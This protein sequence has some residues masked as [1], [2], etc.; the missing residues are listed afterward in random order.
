[1]PTFN[2]ERLKQLREERFW[3]QKELAKK[4]GVNKT[5]ICRWERGV[6]PSPEYFRKLCKVFKVPRETF[7]L[8]EVAK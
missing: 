3:M 2:G 1:M 8:E 5:Q 6:I 7:L 4:L